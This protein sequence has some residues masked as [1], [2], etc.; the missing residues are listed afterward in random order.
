MFSNSYN[1]PFGS[2][3][4]PAPTNHNPTAPLCD[5]FRSQ[6]SFDNIY[7]LNTKQIN[8]N[9]KQIKVPDELD[10]TIYN[11]DLLS[12]GIENTS[13][14]CDYIVDAITAGAAAKWEGD[15]DIS[16]ELSI[17]T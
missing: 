3:T 14:V 5:H 11:H 15:T 2:S 17:H 13:T 9:R 10:Y 6:I 8:P 1:P 12:F 4:T 7:L 16:D